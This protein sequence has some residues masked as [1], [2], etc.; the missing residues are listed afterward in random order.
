MKQPKSWSEVNKKKKLC[1]AVAIKAR[2]IIAGKAGKLL[3]HNPKLGDVKS[4]LETFPATMTDRNACPPG[5]IS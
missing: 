3:G 2:R 5:C 1:E 4:T